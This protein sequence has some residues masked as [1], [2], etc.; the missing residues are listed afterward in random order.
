MP[1]RD[2]AH[3]SCPPRFP[4]INV[5]A[6]GSHDHTP[7]FHLR[8]AGVS[9]VFR[10]D[11]TTRELVHD[12]FGARL[13]G[14]GGGDVGEAP[15]VMPCAAI[16][17]GGW[18]AADTPTPLSHIQRELPDAG[19]GDFRLPAIHAEHGDD[20]STVTRLEYVGHEVTSKPKVPGLPATF[21]DGDRK[22]DGD[23]TVSTLLLHLSCPVTHLQVTLRY[24]I[25]PELDAIARSMRV[26]H[27]GTAGEVKLH[28][29]ASW[30][31][32]FEPRL[33]D[34]IGGA[35]AGSSW[36]MLTLH[37]S[38]AREMNVSRH[39]VHVG[40]QGQQSS[41]GF[42]SA[43]AQ[44]F[45]A[46][47][48]RSTSESQGEC[49]AFALVYSGSHETLVERSTTGLVRVTIGLNP[50]H[51]GKTLA[52]GEYFDTPESIAVYSARDGLGGASRRL[53]RLYR[54]HLIRSQWSQRPRPPL[55]NA[56]EA[57]YFDFDA[58]KLRKIASATGELG[59]RL[60]VCDDG[61]FG[62][63]KHARTSDRAG[64]GDWRP[65]NER[66]PKGFPQFVEDVTQLKV[67]GDDARKL[68]FGLW[69]EPE[70][71]N[72]ASDLYEAHPEWVLHAPRHARTTVR[73][74]LVLNLALSAVQDYLID[75]LS[76]L[77]SSSPGIT[78]VKWDCNR[79]MHEMATPATAHAY[80]L[81]LYRVLDTLTIQRFPHI[82]WEGCASG[83]ARFDAGMLPYFCQSW[84]SD[85]TD[86]VDR[87]AIQFGTT[88]AH[89]ASAMGCH[90]SAVPNHQTG[91]TTPFE[92]R[93]HVAL[94]GG[95]FGFELDV[96]QLTD[97]E[98]AAIPALVALAD[99]VNP[100]VI[101]GD[102]YRL[103][104]PGASNYPAALYVSQ[105]RSRAVLL[106]YVVH[107]KLGVR[108]PPLRLQGLDADATYRLDVV[109]RGG[110]D[111]QAGPLATLSGASL[112]ASGVRLAWEVKD[113]QSRVVMVTKV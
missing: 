16:P 18:T 41:M 105:D 83:G 36:E 7:T 25:F 49:W 42:S 66:F 6:S 23:G 24:T 33:E 64:L 86:A 27:G 50:M 110:S 68:R 74:Q 57:V 98:R 95:S 113:Y 53:H 43:Q 21:V 70:M 100:L 104:Q 56:W 69:V 34:D 3:A 108:W 14:G 103:A 1:I 84:T 40:T 58:D 91:R 17:S 11:P 88:I 5:T 92:F 19:R 61:W 48:D 35:A 10:V 89:P 112:M 4:A 45:V 76:T 94:M 99:R 72:P 12:H 59:I 102:L 44:P 26:T 52:P 8:G 90:V 2:S 47:M 30:S 29:A 20:G 54:S 79:P 32:D 111:G 38:W 28:R 93:A 67:N 65:N 51:L 39:P 101:D 80:M 9:Y 13:T 109:G 22:G 15:L 62:E 107:A 81:G 73:H 85:N 106:A 97:E 37:G 87:L 31:T 55:L 96:Q 82:L 60:F 77:L 71:V 78:Y 46:L 75:T 63:G